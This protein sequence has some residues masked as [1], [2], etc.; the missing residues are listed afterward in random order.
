VQ[1]LVTELRRFR[2][3]QGLRPGQKVPAALVADAALVAY[4]E[5]IGALTD[6]RVSV[7][8]AIPE[9]WESVD[10]DATTLTV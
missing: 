10:V 6:L 5:Q 4:A 2:Q 9:G 1:G 7:Q 8:A 3:G